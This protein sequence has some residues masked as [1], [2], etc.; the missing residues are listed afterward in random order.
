MIKRKLRIP[1]TD[2]VVINLLARFLFLIVN[3][4][5]NRG[6]EGKYT[7]CTDNHGFRSE[8]GKVS[9]KVFDI[10]FMGDSFVEGTSENYE[11][12]FVGMFSKSKKNLKIANLGI[13]S[14]APSIYYSNI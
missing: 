1:I 6:F 13:S 9:G 14:Y 5:N 3:Y 4:K 8:C 2:N 12:T 10:G 7:I 11:N